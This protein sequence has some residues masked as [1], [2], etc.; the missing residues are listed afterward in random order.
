MSSKTH[1]DKLSV[2]CDKL[3][4]CDKLNAAMRQAQCD[5]RQ[6]KCDHATS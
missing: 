3:R 1:F 5:L 4:P 6:A 2:T